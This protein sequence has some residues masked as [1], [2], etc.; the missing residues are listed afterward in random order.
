M[1]VTP[2]KVQVLGFDAATGHDP[3]QVGRLAGVSQIQPL[4]AIR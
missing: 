4:S 3:P 2:P 1:L